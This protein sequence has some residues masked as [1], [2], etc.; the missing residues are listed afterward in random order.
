M[1]HT[2]NLGQADPRTTAVYYRA[3]A[4]RRQREMERVYGAAPSE[5]GTNGRPPS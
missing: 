1:P 4:D 5:L 3:Q 2:S